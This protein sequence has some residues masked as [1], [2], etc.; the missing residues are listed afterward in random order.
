M[1]RRRTPSIIPIV[2]SLGL[3]AGCSGDPQAPETATNGQ[4]LPPVLQA[5]SVQIDN[6]RAAL[7]SRLTRTSRQLFVSA[8]ETPAP[9]VGDAGKPE[10]SSVKL[11]LVGEV[12]PP[13]VNGQ[14]VQANDIDIRGQTAVIAYNF[15]GDAF[16]GAVQV[17]DFSHPDHPELVAEVRYTDADADAVVL[18]GSHLYVGLASDD[19]ALTTPA[20]VAELK[21]TGQGLERTD[22]WLQ[23]P[24]WAVTDL[25]LHGNDLVAS[26]G[27]RDGGVVQIDRNNL[28][29][30]GWAAL[31]DARGVAVDDGQGVMVVCGT[32]AYLSKH[33][34]PGLALQSRASVTGYHIPNAKGTI[35]VASHRCYLGAG[36]G[37]LQVRGS[38][39]Q[40]LATLSNGDFSNVRPDQMVVNAVS[41]T[42]NLAFVAG[43]ALGVQVVDLGRFRCDG[44][45]SDSNYQPRVLGQL[46]FEDDVSSNMVKAKNNILV[47][48]AGLGGVKL[49]KMEFSGGTSIDR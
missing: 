31:P 14:V 9:Q 40:L 3:F 18:D 42:N 8:K 35:E 20:M 36:D 16:A 26:V 33:G 38:D 47:V 24:S 29:V 27:A 45:E 37:G 43:G 15:A 5:K 10:Q 19:P 17:V 49:V 4:P 28:H 21:L 13:S 34:L 23:M 48:A 32:D 11:T 30:S 46:D 44:H 41:V 22:G 7:E 1:K 39:G 2:A 25:A 12:Q 6:D